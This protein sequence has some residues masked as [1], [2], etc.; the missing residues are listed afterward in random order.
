MITAACLQEEIAAL[1]LGDRLHGFLPGR[2]TNNLRRERDE[3]RPEE[4]TYA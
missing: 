1:Q 3:L 2:A 4:C